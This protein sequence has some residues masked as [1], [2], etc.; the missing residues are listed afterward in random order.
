VFIIDYKPAF[1][2]MGSTLIGKTIAVAG[3]I[4]IPVVATSMATPLPVMLRY[5]VSEPLCISP[6][7]WQ[8]AKEMTE[9]GIYGCTNIQLTFNFVPA[10]PVIGY[11]KAVTLVDGKKQY[12]DKL[13][14]IYPTNA[15]IVRST[16][17]HAL[18]SKIQ[19]QAPTS[20]TTSLS[21]PWIQPRCMVTFLTP[22]PDV[23]L[24]LVSTVPYVEF[25]RYFSP[26]SLEE[27]GR[28]SKF[29]VQS[30]TVT[31][32]SIPDFLAVFVKPTV[33]GQTQNESYM[34]IENIGV[35]FDNYSN[36]CSNFTQE[37]LYACTAAAGLDMDWQQ[38]RGYTTTLTPTGLPAVSNSAD[39]SWFD[40]RT[41][42]QATQLSGGPLL[43]RMGQDIPLSPGLAPGT[44]GNFSVQLN[45][46][47]DNQHGFFDYLLGL[48]AN[49]NAT[50]II[51]AVNSGFFETVR[52][53]S[54]VRKAILN[55]VDVE[56]ASTQAGVT[57]SHLKRL[58]GGTMGVQPNAS[59]VS[60]A[61]NGRDAISAYNEPAT[62]SSRL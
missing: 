20:T 60:N 23:T 6:F 27:N 7:L 2:P 58:I 4:S 32:S 61:T 39:P 18:F 14:N 26:A 55:S 33:R 35:T 46:R 48:N 12:A 19:L 51:M 30:N 11:Q 59:G 9:C 41:P 40:C 1:I 38:F 54:A 25:P 37:D 42:T 28:G 57:S 53:Q 17:L 5:Y 36:L 56:A 44:L 24:P 29:Y 13:N 21:G 50:V 34:P 47:L 45:L 15:A 10:G 49:N 43:L 22:P 31:L 62:N 16:G 8:D 52:G 3:G